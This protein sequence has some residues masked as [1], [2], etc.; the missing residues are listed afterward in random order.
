MQEVAIKWKWSRWQQVWVAYFEIWCKP[1][2][3]GWIERRN[4]SGRGGAKKIP[5][6]STSKEGENF[7]SMDK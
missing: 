5:S 6:Q 1:W 2:S 3:I 4:L 7:K